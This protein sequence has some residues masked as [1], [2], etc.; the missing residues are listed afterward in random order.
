MAC[1]GVSQVPDA[2]SLRGSRPPPDHENRAAC[3]GTMAAMAEPSWRA[4]RSSRSRRL[5][6]TLVP[7][8][9]S[10]TSGAGGIAVHHEDGRSR[11]SQ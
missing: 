1:F 4:T 7:G 9:T 8:V 3:G 11:P 6:S 10:L 2:Q 5:C